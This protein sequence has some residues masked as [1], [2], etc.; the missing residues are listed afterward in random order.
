MSNPTV[1][2][3]PPGTGPAAGPVVQ[4]ALKGGLGNRMIQFMAA[5]RLASLVPGCRI[6]NVSLPEWDIALPPIPPGPGPVCRL[7]DTS[8]PRGHRID[9]AGI[10][11]TL[12]DGSAARVEMDHFALDMHNLPSR[13]VAGVL[14][15]S[16][17]APVASFGRD[18]LLIN[19]R[20]DEIF[21]APHPHYT[22]LPIAFYQ[23]L[24]AQTGL[25][26][27][28]L[29]Q[30]D[31]NPYT[32][33]LRAAFPRARFIPSQGAMADFA[34]LRRA[35]NVV[36]AVSTFS[37]LAAWLSEAE[38][39]FLPLSAL[40]NPAQCPEVSLLPLDDPRYRFILFPVNYAV[41]V[42]GFAPAHRALAGTW[43]L[44]QP[45][46]IAEMVCRWPRFP[47]SAHAMRE[48]FDE[49]FY[50]HRYPDVRAGVASG[51]YHSGRE[52]YAWEGFFEGREAFPLDRAWYCR[53]FPLA[54]IEVGQGDFASLHHH[55]VA[56]GRDRGY[57]PL[58]PAAGSP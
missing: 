20:G 19:I 1:P 50:L 58:P 6:G 11:A 46:M 41:P 4:V 12:N 15:R 28:F 3:A 56:V 47:V 8:T 39:V 17:V 29:G 26:P 30:L 2:A 25:A 44:V 52:H 57:R 53:A 32:A 27:A 49:A 24:V 45:D 55:Y 38:R 36:V 9:L 37:W 35:R 43:R 51:A 34:T 54:A 5:F 14:F 7:F 40:F 18:T 42:A 31:P 23:E 21:A 48:A 33:A 16:D 13:D 10:A 22:L